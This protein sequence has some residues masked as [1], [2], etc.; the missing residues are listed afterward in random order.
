MKKNVL[1]MAFMGMMLMTANGMSAQIDLKGLADQVLSSSSA[2]QGSNGS[3]DLIQN[4]TTVFSKDK[5]AS[6]NNIV[7]TWSYTEPAIV[8][9]SGNFLSNA[10]Y[11]IAANKIENKLQSYLTQYGIKP[12]TFV[13]TFKE[14]GTFT[15]T[16]K[17]KE[18]SG[19]WEIQNEKLLLTIGK[20]KAV[21]ITTQISGKEMQLVTDATKLLNMFQSF[22]ANSSNSSIKT[23]AAL[24]KGVKEMQAGIT[25]KKQ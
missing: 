1:K 7:G 3:G 19:K 17:G 18:M 2:Q 21:K 13:I 15:E 22:G 23:A 10:A 14:D 11:K 25:L 24:L 8:L 6:K 16:L 20:V 9:N 4:L 12:G 5:Q